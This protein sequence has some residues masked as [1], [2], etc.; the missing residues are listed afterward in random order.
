[1]TIS[2]G[3]GEVSLDDPIEK[4]AQPT[5]YMGEVSKWLGKNFDRAHTT[6]AIKAGVGGKSAKVTEA[7]A[8][9][10]QGG[11]IEEKHPNARTK[12]YQ[13]VKD[14]RQGEETKPEGS[15]GG[16]SDD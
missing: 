2:G 7:I 9:L 12:A 4:A 5:W 8:L 15:D 3:K 13:H 6:S 10:V 14:Y 16:W 1:M 11:Y